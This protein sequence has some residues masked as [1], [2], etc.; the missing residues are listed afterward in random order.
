M[1][2]KTQKRFGFMTL[3]QYAKKPLYSR[4]HILYRHKNGR[5]ARAFNSARKMYVQIKL[6]VIFSPFG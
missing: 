4:T 3:L 6:K 2:F 1:F 5:T